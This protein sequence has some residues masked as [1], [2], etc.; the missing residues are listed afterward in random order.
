MLAPGA[1]Y[2][3]NEA[4]RISAN[5][6]AEYTLA[7]PSRRQA[8]LRNAKFAPTFLVI[9]YNEARDAV[10]KYLTDGTRPVASL[11]N[12]AASL[13]AKAAE[14]ATDFKQND[15][16]MSAEAISS[17]AAFMTDPKQAPPKVFTN[18]FFVRP[19]GTLPKLP[20]NGTEVSVQIDLISLNKAK[21]TCGGV[22]LQTSKAVAS[23]T[24]RQEHAA[25]VATLVWMATA[26]R[27]A[28]Y[29]TVD[30]SICF[31]VD[32]FARAAVPAP[33]SFKTRAKDLS[34]ACAEIA[35]LWGSINPPPDFTL[36]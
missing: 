25:N 24:W 7:S 9:R 19:V 33:S 4:P 17:F 31:S 5:Q 14:A 36:P 15:F 11:H 32:L 6:L 26:E 20:V 1:K 29:G 35:A 22:V 28:G 27:L 18:L 12:D 3:L 2:R 8:I 23:K 13:K 21:E 16:L 10:T 30:R 34:A